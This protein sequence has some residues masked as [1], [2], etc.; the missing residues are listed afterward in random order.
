MIVNLYL[1]ASEPEQKIRGWPSVACCSP[2]FLFLFSYIF[3]LVLD[4]K[5]Y[6]CFF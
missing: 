5:E 1:L 2:E 6:M 4:G 3:N